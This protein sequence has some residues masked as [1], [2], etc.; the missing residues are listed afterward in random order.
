MSMMGESE[1]E[2]F[3][4]DGIPGTAD[5]V[6]AAATIASLYI[7]GNDTS[8]LILAGASSFAAGTDTTGLTLLK[9]GSI[10]AV[11]VL[12]TVSDDSRF[13]AAHV[14]RVAKLDGA[15]VATSGDPHFSI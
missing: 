8:S 13:L 4:D 5:D 15:R 2:A 12:G 11:T 3:G 9:K 14:P 10:L 7:G 6:F 1:L